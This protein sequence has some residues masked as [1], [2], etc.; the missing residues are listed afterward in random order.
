MLYWCDSLLGSPRTPR[1]VK[2]ADVAPSP[3]PVSGVT[4]RPVLRGRIAQLNATLS[5]TESSVLQLTSQVADMQETKEF[6]EAEKM[7]R[8]E[9][10]L[11]HLAEDDEDSQVN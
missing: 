1:R 7:F 2:S 8:E 4:P 10:L 11:A 6:I 5:Q 9:S 3:S